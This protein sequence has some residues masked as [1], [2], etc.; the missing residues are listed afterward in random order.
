ME[1][2]N[3]FNVFTFIGRI[4]LLPASDDWVDT[5]RVPARVTSIEGNFQATRR[6]FRTN[7]RGFALFNGVL[8]ELLGLV[9]EELTVVLGEKPHSVVVYRDV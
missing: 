4:D 9:L 1:N 5:R 8:G 7:N 6:R 2:V 3:P